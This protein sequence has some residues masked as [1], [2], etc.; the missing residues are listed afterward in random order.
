M[1]GAPDF[2]FHRIRVSKAPPGAACIPP[3]LCALLVQLVLPDNLVIKI[4]VTMGSF[5]KVLT[6]Y[7]GYF[8][9]RGISVAAAAAIRNISA[10]TLSNF[11][12]KLFRS[13][14]GKYLRF[15]FYVIMTQSYFV[16]L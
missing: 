13:S 3:F 14:H 7:T 12:V 11:F 6:G 2:L 9:L 5:N 16:N 15:F 1:C 10:A 4:D 8:L